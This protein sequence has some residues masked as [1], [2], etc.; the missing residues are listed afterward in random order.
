MN[1]HT[2]LTL[3]ETVVPGLTQYQC[4]TDRHRLPMTGNAVLCIGEYDAA[5]QK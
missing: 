2:N 3:P 1:N 4:V 5:L